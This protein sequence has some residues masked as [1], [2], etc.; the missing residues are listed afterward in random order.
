VEV[1]SSRKDLK[2]ISVG[3]KSLC[4]L[5]DLLW[6]LTLSASIGEHYVALHVE[7]HSDTLGHDFRVSLEPDKAKLLCMLKVVPMA[8]GDLTV[9]SLLDPVNLINQ[10]VAKFLHHLE[11]KPVLSVDDPDKQVAFSWLQ[12]GE[13]DLE[14]LCITQSV[15]GDGDTSGRVGS[16][17]LPGRVYSHYVKAA[18]TRDLHL[19]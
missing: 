2:V 7:A 12:E 9:D 4:Y 15:V 1:V 19:L 16:R 6:F 14:D 18:T 3:H 5:I 17:Q 10:A 11:G 13:G 8:F